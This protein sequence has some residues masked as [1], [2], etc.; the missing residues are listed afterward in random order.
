MPTM[1][2]PTDK[3]FVFRPKPLVGPVDPE[4]KAK[5]LGKPED[6]PASPEREKETLPLVNPMGVSL[7]KC[8]QATTNDQ[9]LTHHETDSYKSKIASK[10]MKS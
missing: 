9:C 2:V 7:G 1:L 8:R 4:I 6:Q 3:R 5:N 10:D